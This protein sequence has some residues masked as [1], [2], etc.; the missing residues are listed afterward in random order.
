[1]DSDNLFEAMKMFQ[2]GVKELS[3]SNAL[4]QANDAVQQVK[5]SGLKAHEQ[6]AQLNQISNQ[7]VTFMA[8]QGI[9][10]TTIEQVSA[11]LAGPKLSTANTMNAYALQTG[12]AELEQQ[13]AKQQAF[14]QNPEYKKQLLHT[15]A[16][17]AASKPDRGEEKAWM[18]YADSLDLSRESNRKPLGQWANVQ[19]RGERTK[20]VLGTSTNG[21]YTE[22]QLEIVVDGLVQQVKGGV[23]T[24]EESERLMQW[25]APLAKARAQAKLTGKPVKFDLS[26]FAD[27]YLDILNR[28]ED[29]A[30]EKIQQFILARA[31]NRPELV[32]KNPEQA[33]FLIAN[34]LSAALGREIS[35]S[36]IVQ[37]G[38]KFKLSSSAPKT[39]QAPAGMKR[40]KVQGPNGLVDALQGPDGKLYSIPVGQ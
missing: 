10:A 36:Q 12:D 9:P 28:E 17:I 35:P 26:G 21:M 13:A 8:G 31:S 19:A 27:M 33:K 34:N 32:G 3:F 1:M 38:K 14:E 24:K 40:V 16:L 25:S 37:V 23:P 2:Q 22:Q 39:T 6:K 18:N 20:A 5:Q 7:L 11:S 4:S 29:L 30:N 15:K